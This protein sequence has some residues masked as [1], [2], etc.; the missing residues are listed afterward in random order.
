M[1]SV[2]L[3]CPILAWYLVFLFLF[4]LP[5]SFLMRERKKDVDLGGW[6]DGEALEG[7]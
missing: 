1:Y 7:V 6:G 5:V 3:L 2:P 4:W